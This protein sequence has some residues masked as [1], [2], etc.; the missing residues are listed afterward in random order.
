[1]C[2]AAKA[3]GLSILTFSIGIVIGMFCPMQVLA[4]IELF[5][6]FL[7]GYLCLFKW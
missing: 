3:I 1:M 2:G 5:M 7:F 6:L 4:V